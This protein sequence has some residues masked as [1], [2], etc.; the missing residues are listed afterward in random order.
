[1]HRSITF[2][3]RKLAWPRITLLALTLA[4]AGS[5]V[6][7]ALL[8]NTDRIDRE[9][10]QLWMLLSQARARAMTEGPVTVRFSGQIAHIET[11]TARIVESL[12]LR[13]LDEVRF[14]TTQGD[15][16]I[17][18]S[19]GGQTSPYNIHLHGGDI[20]LRSWA[21]DSRSIWIHCTGGITEGRNSDWTLNKR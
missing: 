12:T 8:W 20:T 3:C 11:S 21:G 16:R 14:Q 2:H 15:D 9:F 10:H 18:F 1:M 6:A 5:A 7:D 19:T 13:T 4:L 17:V